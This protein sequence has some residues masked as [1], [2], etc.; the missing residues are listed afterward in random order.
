MGSQ[1]DV[2]RIQGSQELLVYPRNRTRTAS[3]LLSNR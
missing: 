2:E 1:E 3:E